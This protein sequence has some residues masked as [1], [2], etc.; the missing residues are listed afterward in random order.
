MTGRQLALPFPHQSGFAAAD[1]LRA[2]SNEAALAW[3]D[4]VA[5]WPDHRLAL[6]GEQ[7]CGKTHLLHIW[8][9]RTGAS[10]MH[11]PSLR[12]LPPPPPAAGVAIDD[13]DLP[14][15]E[16]ALLH[17][18]NTCRDAGV[19]VLM[20]AIAPPARWR[21]ALA[22]LRSRLRSVTAVEIPPPDDALL[23][24]LLAR[25]LADRQLAVP[26][27]LQDW[28]LLRLPRT[29]AALREAVA[30]LDRAALAA[31]GRVTRAL[32]AEVLTIDDGDH[33]AR[34]LATSACNAG[35]NL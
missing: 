28:L 20:A 2:P 34:A 29:P 23:R 16:T 33:V 24:V 9:G 3:L 18:L 7:G 32:A 22:D 25:L 14:A 13:A 15:E 11:G 19:P 12:G 5:D 27:W 30:R 1:F 17:L 35:G 6:W 21:I 8:T 4:R 31:G 26:N 10:L